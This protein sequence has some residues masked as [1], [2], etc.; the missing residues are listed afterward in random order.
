MT[1]LSLLLRTP[2]VPIWTHAAEWK[3]TIPLELVITLILSQVCKGCQE[4]LLG[5]KALPKRFNTTEDVRTRI[6][7]PSPYSFFTGW[8]EFDNQGKQTGI[9]SEK[10]LRFRFRFSL[11]LVH[12]TG[13]D[14]LPR[15]KG[16]NRTPRSL[17]RCPISPTPQSHT[18]HSHSTGITLLLFE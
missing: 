10:C 14:L 13:Q 6:V 9:L 4:C 8:L 1:T 17:T 16:H 7:L 11:D 3:N 5:N 12:F 15:G 2:L 18:K